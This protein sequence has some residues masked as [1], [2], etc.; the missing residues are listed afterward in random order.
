M[1]IEYMLSLLRSCCQTDILERIPR[2]LMPELF[3][4]LEADSK[5][6]FGFGGGLEAS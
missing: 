4:K 3:E 2:M 5:T 6:E 1:L